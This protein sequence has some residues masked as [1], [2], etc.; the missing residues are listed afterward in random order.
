MRQVVCYGVLSIVA[1]VI[2]GCGSK[3]QTASKAE[4]EEADF[5][6]VQHILIG[7]DGSVQG[8]TITR[9]REVAGT[10]AQELSERAKGGEDF[11]ELVRQY[12]DDSYPGIYDLANKDADADPT[13][14]IYARSAMVPAF[15]DV[16]FSLAVNEVGLA[17]YDKSDCRFGWHIIM[18][19][20]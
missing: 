2:V 17:R 20:K 8:K 14:L 1:M 9:T 3:N 7:F 15:G 18:R 16:A 12:T 6:A 10:L 19:L 13:R 5:I 11:D 4:R